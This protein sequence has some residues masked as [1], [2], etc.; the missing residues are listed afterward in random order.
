MSV[1]HI[2]ESFKDMQGLGAWIEVDLNRLETNYHRLSTF[3]SD[4]MIFPVVKANAYGH[5]M[6]PIARFYESLGVPM[7]CVSSVYEAKALLESGIKTDILIFGWT[8][9]R[10]MKK[11]A[12]PQIIYTL[13]SLHMYEQIANHSIPYRL[14]IKI[15]SGMNRVGFKNVDEL[16]HILKEDKHHY[17]GIYTHLPSNQ[18][19]RQTEKL[20]EDFL[21][22]VD[23][24][25]TK[26]KWVHTGNTNPGYVIDSQQ[27]NAVR[28]GMACFGYNDYV[29]VNPIL[30]LYAPIE[31]VTSIQEGDTVGYDFSYQAKKDEWIVSIP[32]GYAHGFFQE[33]DRL[34]FYLNGEKL[35]LV[36]KVCM[37]QSM[38]KAEKRI[39]EG[40]RLCVYG[41]ERSLF[42]LSQKTNKSHYE[43]L[44]QL[45]PSIPR[46]Y[47]YEENN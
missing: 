13:S 29:E 28:H 38:L 37:D 12:H 25:E 34:A 24:L 32:L 9:P 10:L 22:L 5:G 11:Y 33:Q 18:K 16:K 4:K 43:L 20:F 31:Y 15:N 39:Q 46:I 42:D 1:I 17:E 30:S 36:G 21:T 8:D 47:Y 3:Y 27:I 14:H 41:K 44:T 35:S 6:L 23:S 40:H 2:Q 7:L 19:T 26:F 45:S